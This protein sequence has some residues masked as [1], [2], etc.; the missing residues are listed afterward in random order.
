LLDKYNK[1]LKKYLLFSN[2]SKCTVLL[3][4]K[5]LLAIWNGL[6]TAYEGYTYIKSLIFCLQIGQEETCLLFTFSKH[7][8][9]KHI[10]VHGNNTIEGLND[11]RHIEH[12]DGSHGS[13]I[14]KNI[15]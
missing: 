11:S 7:S 6:N 3:F 9:Q 8:S 4:K 10:C 12:L 5:K 13:S 1:C 2:K 15:L 14:N